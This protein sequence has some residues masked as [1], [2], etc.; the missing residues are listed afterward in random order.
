[1]RESAEKRREREVELAPFH[2]KE[3]RKKRRRKW[4]KE[5]GFEWK[6]NSAGFER[7]REREREKHT[8]C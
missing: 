2:G 5:F 7:E 4:R 6:L 3:E 8:G 1:M